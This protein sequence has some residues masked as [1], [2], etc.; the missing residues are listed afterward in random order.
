MGIEHKTRT[1]LVAEAIREKILSGEIKAGEPLRQA[2]L[3]DELNVSR[4]PVREALLQLESEGLVNFEAHKGATATQ[5]SAEQIDEI[6]DLRA[7]LE[8][9]LLSH[10]IANLTPR[11]LLEA[12]A[13]LF[14]LEEA[15]A[16]GDT[17]S[18][19]GKLNAQFHSKLYS[20]AQRPQT[21][22]LVDVYSKN[23]ER[24]VR[25]HILLAGG[26]NTAPEEHRTL[27]ELC[28]NKDV[29]QACAFLKK[30]ITGAKD[31]IKQLLIKMEQN[32][33]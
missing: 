16:A 1:Q 18:A 31:D 2:A 10:S 9:E 7:L 30:H 14:D 24:Y 25:M 29:E 22:E 5:L 33:K 21:A 6:F 26:I 3:A 15:T 8:A 13:I 11:D 20:K 23:S 17:E 27:L 4:I 19:T 28:K 32:H 12:E